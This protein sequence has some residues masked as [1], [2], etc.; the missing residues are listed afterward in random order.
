MEYAFF[1]LHRKSAQTKCTPLWEHCARKEKITTIGNSVPP[2]RPSGI[3]VVGTKLRPPEDTRSTVK[4]LR[5]VKH[6]YPPS[7][8]LPSQNTPLRPPKLSRVLPLTYR[9]RS[10]YFETL[11]RTRP[12][13][14]PG[15]RL[16]TPPQGPSSSSIRSLWDAR[17]SV[18]AV[19]K[20]TIQS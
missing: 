16:L 2:P 11:G 17:E 20:T 1:C 12:V 10:D 7:S 3:A 15:C 6:N 9:Q 8:C 5:H 14:S 13:R 4:L 18:L 19:I